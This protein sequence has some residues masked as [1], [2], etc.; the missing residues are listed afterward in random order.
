LIVDSGPL[1]AY[2]DA[3]DRHHASSLELLRTHP[4]PLL[5]PTL[6]VTEVV[7]LLK[8][9]LST[10]AEVRFLGDLASGELQVEPVDPSDWLRIAELDLHDTVPLERKRGVSFDRLL[11]QIGL[12][13]TDPDVVSSVASRLTRLNRRMTTADRTEV[14]EVAGVGLTEL[15]RAMVNAL[16]VDRQYGAAAAEADGDPTPDQVKAAAKAMIGEALKPLAGNSAFREKLV[17]VSRMTGRFGASNVGDYE[18]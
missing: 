8:T 6:V 14:E 3:D 1:Y 5:V 11:N 15:V 18:N 2:V 13:S 16:D 10:E 12:G 4:G 9:R 17:D 7:H